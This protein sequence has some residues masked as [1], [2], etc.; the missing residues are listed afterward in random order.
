M[1]KSCLDS[2]FVNLMHGNARY[3]KCW[4]VFKIVLTLSHGQVAVEREFSVNKELL[5][6]NLQQTSVISQ[7][8]I[9][10]YVVDIPKS[11]SEIPL[12]NKML[13]GT[14]NIKK[15]RNATVLQDKSLKRKLK[16]EEIAE[17]RVQY[18]GEYN[19]AAEKGNNLFDFV[20]KS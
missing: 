7:R 14:S 16:L 15:K 2:S 1:K 4:T 20:G 5:F 13:I 18:I 9:Y 3:G 8:L 10:D 17:V 11:T 19:I 6:E 12:T